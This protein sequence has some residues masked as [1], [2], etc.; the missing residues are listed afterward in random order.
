[1]CGEENQPNKE[2]WDWGGDGTWRCEA[3]RREMELAERPHGRLFC[4]QASRASFGFC[5]ACAAM[6]A[7]SLPLSTSAPG[8]ESKAASHLPGSGQW[9]GLS[10]WTSSVLTSHPIPSTRCSIHHL[11]REM[12]LFSLNGPGSACHVLIQ[13]LGLWVDAGWHGSPVA[14]WPIM[15][16]SSSTLEMPFDKDNAIDSPHLLAPR[17]VLQLTNI[18]RE[19]NCSFSSV[20]ANGN[21]VARRG[22]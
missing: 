21:N 2:E 17:C 3:G 12:P 11:R 9:A 8:V 6:W 18:V 7:G 22:G 15:L 20:A 10:P 19:I 5:S 1:M 13:S 16:W 14:H 4:K